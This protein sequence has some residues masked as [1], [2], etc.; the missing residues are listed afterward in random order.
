MEP[1]APSASADRESAGRMRRW[2][3]WLPRVLVESAF[4]VFSVLLALAL[5]AWWQSRAERERADLALAGIRSEVEANRQAAERARSFHREIQDTLQAIAAA[6]GVPSAD[7]YYQRGMFKPAPV[8]ATAWES[9]RTTAILDRVPYALVL[10]LSY[11][12]TSQAK[13]QELGDRIV[14]DLFTEMRTASVEAVLRDGFRGFIL[15][16]EDFANRESRLIE[17]YDRL[18]A[19]LDERSNGFADQAAEIRSQDD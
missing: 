4:I 13:Y 19:N 17:R 9:A 5:D 16:T 6:G 12:Y 3:G 18:L 7:I 8:V 14:A 10:E 11:I 2:P 15:L 1:T